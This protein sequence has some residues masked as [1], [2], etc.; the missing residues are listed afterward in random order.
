MKTS[1]E[2]YPKVEKIVS[3]SDDPLLVSLFMAAVGNSID[4]AVGLEADIVKIYKNFCR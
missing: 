3:N 2:I 4:T 1:L